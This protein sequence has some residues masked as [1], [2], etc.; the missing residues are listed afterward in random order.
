L[1]P[2]ERYNFDLNG[3][4]KQAEIQGQKQQYKTAEYN[5]L[6]SDNDS[7]YKYDLE[8]NR[9]AKISNDGSTLK[10]YW[11]NRN[12]LIKI[13]TPNGTIE[14]IYDHLNRIVQRKQGETM[15]TF[16]HDGWQ[17]VLQFDNDKPTHRYLWGTK[18]DDLICDND[19]WTLNDH[20]NTIRD[21]VKSDGT[22]TD[23][24]EYNSFGKIIS[25]TKNDS[26]L[27]FAY[28]GKLTDKESDLQWNI[29]RWYDAK[30]G[31]WVSEDPI[32]FEGGDGNL[33]T[34][35]GNK[36]SNSYDSLGLILLGIDGTWSEYWLEQGQFGTMV[37]GVVVA[38]LAKTGT[39]RWLSH[40]RNFVNEYQETEK[41]Y[42][43][44]PRK[45]KTAGDLDAIIQTGYD[46]V[47]AQY[48]TAT[49]SNGK[50]KEI[51]L[52]GHSRG[53]VAVMEVARKL[54]KDACG[55]KTSSGKSCKINVRFVGLY[56]PVVGHPRYAVK[57]TYSTTRPS[58]IKTL[59][60]AGAGSFPGGLK[61]SRSAWTRVNYGATATELK[62]FAATHGG[63]GGAPTYD[64]EEYGVKGVPLSGGSMPDGYTDAA[65]IAGS[66]EADQWIRSQATAADVPIAPVGNYGF[67]SLLPWNKS[68]QASMG[69]YATLD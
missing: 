34:Y 52:V 69:V 37:N 20:L 53:G 13:E 61:I 8:G 38:R 47:C 19:N 48:K 14:Y 6:I 10:Y 27:Q 18:Q 60:I 7:E 30:V 23:H 64:T 62:S 50:K 15:T 39:N 24:L 68:H 17:I 28:T 4:R 44:G 56:D 54:E 58:N 35:V 32:G 41:K 43:H 59:R 49:A 57:F 45:G 3:N 22:V 12:R 36:V 33:Y 42:L 1:T 51:D 11:D 31:R 66:I 65:D 2:N 16:I 55:L 21:I 46:W 26:S 9:I 63:L 29:N 25:A 5:R 40:V 67:G